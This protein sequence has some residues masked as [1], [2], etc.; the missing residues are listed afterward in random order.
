M[1]K[2]YRI[3]VDYRKFGDIFIEANSLDEAIELAYGPEKLPT[4]DTYMEDSIMVDM[5]I[6]KEY[7]EDDTLISK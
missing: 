6:L 5:E 4:E 7:L 1:K 2:T 3:P